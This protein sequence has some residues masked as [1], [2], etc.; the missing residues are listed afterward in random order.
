MWE[1]YGLE[2]EDF[3]WTGVPFMGGISG[4]QQAP[5][6][7]VSASSVSLGLRHRCSLA[8]KEK[9]KQSRAVIRY[10]AA[11]L[12]KSFRERFGNI[13]CMDLVGMDF[14]EPGQY[15]KFLASGIWKEKC[16]KYVEFAVEK[17]YEF[18]ER[19]GVGHVPQGK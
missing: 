15:Q 4:Q 11:A 14:S 16:A 12:V 1:T 13:N 9:A 8:D 19:S 7:A 17:L 3:L 10:Y 18:E 6:G 2:N 5:C